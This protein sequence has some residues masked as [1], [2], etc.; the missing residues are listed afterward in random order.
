MEARI[1]CRDLARLVVRIS[2]AGWAEFVREE[3]PDS[4]PLGAGGWT[5]TLCDYDEWWRRVDLPLTSFLDAFDDKGVLSP[6]F[7]D[8]RVRVYATRNPASMPP[9][10]AVTLAHIR[11]RNKNRSVTDEAREQHIILDGFHRLGGLILRGDTS[12]PAYVPWSTP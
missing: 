6:P 8:H 11:V 7:I 5:E 12:V 4:S 2:H 3:E 9:L 1:H 10:I